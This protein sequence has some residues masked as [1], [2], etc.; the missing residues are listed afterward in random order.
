MSG[1]D[2]QSFFCSARGRCWPVARP[3]RVQR[4]VRNRRKQTSILRKIVVALDRS[5]Q[6]DA[7]YSAIGRPVSGGYAWRYRGGY[8]GGYRIPQLA[9]KFPRKYKVLAD[10]SPGR[11]NPDLPLGAPPLGL[12]PAFHLGAGFIPNCSVFPLRSRFTIM[13][14]SQMDIV[15]SLGALL[16]ISRPGC[17]SRR[18]IGGTVENKQAWLRICVAVDWEPAKG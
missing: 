3:R 15:A 14:F 10:R 1:P 8:A 5:A 7:P 13:A 16:R 17:A 6:H 2:A 11:I 4:N 18:F 12:N 9:S